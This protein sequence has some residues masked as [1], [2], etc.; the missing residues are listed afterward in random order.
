MARVRPDSLHSFAAP[1]LA[2]SNLRKATDTPPCRV[3]SFFTPFAARP[4]CSKA[5]QFCRWAQKAAMS[6]QDQHLM[7]RRP[8]TSFRLSRAAYSDPK[9][10]QGN[11]RRRRKEGGAGVF[12][13]AHGSALL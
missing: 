3:G 1:G 6:K 5:E 8:L 9:S 2:D 10:G 13:S 12:G 11:D 4:S 7:P